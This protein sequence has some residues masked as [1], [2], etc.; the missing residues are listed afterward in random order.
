M[1]MS[2]KLTFVQS[3]TEHRHCL[4]NKLSQHLDKVDR[5]QVTWKQKLLLYKAGICPRMS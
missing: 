3:T 2:H 5:T 4:S 1:I